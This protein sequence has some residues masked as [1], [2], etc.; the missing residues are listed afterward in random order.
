M[1]VFYKSPV[2]A[3]VSFR[4][5]SHVKHLCYVLSN[6]AGNFILSLLRIKAKT[7]ISCLLSQ[8]S[9]RLFPPTMVSIQLPFR[10]LCKLNYYLHCFKIMPCSTS[11]SLADPEFFFLL[12][13]E[14]LAWTF[15][16]YCYRRVV[17][18]FLQKP[19]LQGMSSYWK[20]FALIQYMIMLL[21]KC[22]CLA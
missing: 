12:F 22:V 13:W 9:V 15:A 10:I 19:S 6:L 14:Q 8:M 18:D 5:M 7:F 4:L 20:W 2:S 17:L 21:L 3:A 16:L 11:Q 1:P